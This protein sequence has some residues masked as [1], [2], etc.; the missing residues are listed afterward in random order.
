MK[1]MRYLVMLE[2]ANLWMVM[3][4]LKFGFFTTRYLKAENPNFAINAAIALIEQELFGGKI[5]K[6]SPIDPPVFTVSAIREIGW[7][8]FILKKPGKGFT[9]FPEN[10]SDYEKIVSDD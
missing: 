6:N 9:F 10:E 7:L 5:I 3:N 4:D 1:K 2:G 8:E